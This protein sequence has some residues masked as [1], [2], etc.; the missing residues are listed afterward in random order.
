[1][2]GLSD[3]DLALRARQDSD[4]FAVLFDRHHGRVYSYVYHRV[5]NVPDAEDLTS[6]VF[7]QA[8]RGI[9]SYQSRGAPFISWLYRIA[10][11]IIVNWHRDTGRKPVEPLER[12]ADRAFDGADVTVGS[13]QAEERRELRAAIGKL[14]LDRQMLLVWRF[15][16]ER[17]TA[18]IAREMQ[19]TEGAVKALL[20]RTI[21]ALRQ[22]LLRHRGTES[23]I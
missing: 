10:H 9:G 17:S 13:L 1:M 22:E 19:R 16:E 2:L 21:V 8:L 3:D 15:V 12:A 14:P 7:F 20:H 4:A 11:N 18:E 23:R 5:G 6:R